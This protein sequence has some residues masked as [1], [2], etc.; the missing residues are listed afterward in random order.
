MT[1]FESINLRNAAF[2]RFCWNLA[3]LARHVQA[4]RRG[5]AAVMPRG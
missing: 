5:A 4:R 2:A 3:S 1:W